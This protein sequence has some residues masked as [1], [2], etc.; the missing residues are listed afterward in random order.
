MLLSPYGQLV[1]NGII[2]QDI[3]EIVSSWPGITDSDRDKIS[4]F[5]SKINKKDKEDLCKKI[6]VRPSRVIATAHQ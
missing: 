5:L 4:T 6:W 1:K 3:E 2:N